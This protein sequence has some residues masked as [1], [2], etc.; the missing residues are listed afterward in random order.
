[1]LPSMGDEHDVSIELLT[2]DPS[3]GPS[4][5][6]SESASGPETCPKRYLQVIRLVPNPFDGVRGL[7]ASLRWN[8]ITNRSRGSRTCLK[9]PRVAT[10]ARDMY[11]RTYS[12]P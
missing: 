1:M 3:G 4:S 2:G 12:H 5:F 10:R 9:V 6:R 11:G 8:T 7:D